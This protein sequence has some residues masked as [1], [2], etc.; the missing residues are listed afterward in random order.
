MFGSIIAT[1]LVSAEPDEQIRHQPWK[2]RRM[3]RC[4]TNPITSSR[5]AAEYN[6]I[7]RLEDMSEYQQ[8][9][10]KRTERRTKRIKDH[11]HALK[12]VDC[13]SSSFL[14]C[15]CMRAFCS[16]CDAH[17]KSRTPSGRPIPTKT[18]PNVG[19]HSQMSVGPPVCPCSR[20]PAI[21]KALDRS[22]PSPSLEGG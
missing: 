4:C 19:N 20:G 3:A 2:P 1:V 21:Q 14:S 10:V 9:H 7:H 22:G 17:L 11:S 12:R 5:L 16:V 6:Q 18:F 15:S 13:M 8:R